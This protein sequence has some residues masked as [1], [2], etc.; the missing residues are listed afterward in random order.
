MCCGDGLLDDVY[1]GCCG[2]GD[3]PLQEAKIFHSYTVEG[4]SGV[5]SVFKASITIMDRIGMAV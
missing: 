5:Q 3:M 4:M 1:G 2:G